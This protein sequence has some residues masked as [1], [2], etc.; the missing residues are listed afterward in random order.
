MTDILDRP[1]GRR[2]AAVR[3]QPVGRIHGPKLLLVGFASA[4]GAPPDAAGL[5]V[6]D[7]ARCKWSPFNMDIECLLLPD[8]LDLAAE[9]V[10]A[11]LEA[12]GVRGV[13]FSVVDLKATSFAIAFREGETT[14]GADAP[15][16]NLALSVDRPADHIAE[17]VR[18]EDLG[19][20]VVFRWADTPVAPLFERLRADHPQIPVGCLVTPQATEF[21]G[22][23][24][25]RRLQR[26]IQAAAMAHVGWMSLCD[27]KAGRT[28]NR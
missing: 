20:G 12:G 13:L 21:R 1:E 16:A 14:D 10:N 11:R 25:L 18:S 24:P 27:C 26:G 22:L 5:V 19:C 2:I 3:N 6:L 15:A 23:L 17:A 7:L 8:R 9:R 4:A 28:A